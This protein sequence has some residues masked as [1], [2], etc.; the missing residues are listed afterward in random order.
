[1]SFVGA[2]MIM[3]I[4]LCDRHLRRQPGRRVIF[5]LSLA[6]AASAVVYSLTPLL[7]RLDGA[8]FT[9][10]CDLQALAGIFFPVASFVWTDC[11]AYV[12]YSGSSAAVNVLQAPRSK[13]SEQLRFAF[14]C[15][16]SWG[17]PSLCVGFVAGFNREGFSNPNTQETATGGWC[18]IKRVNQS[19][20]PGTL[21]NNSPEEDQLVWEVIGG[22]FVEWTSIFVIV[23][24]LYLLTHARVRRVIIAWAGSSQRRERQ[25]VER[26]DSLFENASPGVGAGKRSDVNDKVELHLP[27]QSLASIDGFRAR[28]LLVP[29]LLLLARIWGSLRTVLSFVPALAPY[30]TWLAYLQA[31]FDPAQG[32][33][34]SIVFI[35]LNARAR[36]ALCGSCAHSRRARRA[37]RSFVLTGSATW[38][39]PTSI[40]AV[41]SPTRNYS[42]TARSLLSNSQR[43]SSSLLAA[44]EPLASVVN[45][46]EGSPAPA[47]RLTP[48]AEAT[49]P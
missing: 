49:P 2:T 7:R 40:R 6:D 20:D 47:R 23:P 11:L 43:L 41:E 1:M 12:V 19:D 26:R 44:T 22:R 37:D 9:S 8:A 25:N 32:W 42:S 21:I 36:A 35:L 45:W 3:A 31:F 18:W 4:S 15:L 10:L 27:D 29:A 46:E 16:L 5:C 34:N 39:D 17:V 30:I 13:A 38:R 28:L 33:L 24:L 14:F 48:P